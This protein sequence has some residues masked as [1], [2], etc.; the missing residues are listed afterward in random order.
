MVPFFY[1]ARFVFTS[2]TL[3]NEECNSY[4]QN[5]VFRRHIGLFAARVVTSAAE[6]E[7]Y[8]NAKVA[9]LW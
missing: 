1:T 4:K 6:R 7:V 8:L 9:R 2:T 5:C 3:F